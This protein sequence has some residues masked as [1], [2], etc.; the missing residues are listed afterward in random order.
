M[1]SSSEHDLLFMAG[2]LHNAS[3][4]APEEERWPYIQR[5][6]EEVEALVPRRLLV[7]G[8]LGVAGRKMEDGPPILERNHQKHLGLSMGNIWGFLK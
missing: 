4:I 7:L 5:L 1:V 6:T 2:Q 3:W 8:G